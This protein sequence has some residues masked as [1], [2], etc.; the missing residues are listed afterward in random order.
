MVNN[1]T[2]INKTN[3]HLW[4]RFVDHIKYY[5]INTSLSVIDSCFISQ[6]LRRTNEIMEMS[7]RSQWIQGP[8]WSYDT[9]SIL[10]IHTTENAKWFIIFKTKPNVS[11]YFNLM[12]MCVYIFNTWRKPLSYRTS[13]MNVV[14]RTL[15]V[16]GITTLRGGVVFN[17]FQQ[18]YSYI[19]VVSFIGGGDR[20]YPEKT[21]DLSQVTDK[22]YHIMLYISSWEGFEPTTLVNLVYDDCIC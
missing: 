11:M 4:P 18:Y 19:V 7:S 3:N 21:I 8:S 10:Y 1:S 16:M 14:Y 13:Q 9:I 15:T 22:I 5:D 2:N 20:V 6:I 12:Q 17:H